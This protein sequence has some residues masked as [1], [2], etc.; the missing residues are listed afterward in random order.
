MRF[1]AFCPP[2]LVCL[3]LPQPGAADEP[4]F[5]VVSEIRGGVLAHDVAFLG[6]SEEEGV[7]INVELLFAAPWAAGRA[8]IVGGLLSPRP[9]LGLQA[10]TDGGASQAY[11]G[12]SW[13]IALAARLWFGLAAG[14][15]LHN[16]DLDDGPRTKALGSRVLFRLA[17][18]IGYDLTPALSVSLYYDHES[19]AGFAKDNEGLNNAGIRIGWLF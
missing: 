15:A 1:A 17:G 2:A 9:H 14:G 6:E 4:L 8:G 13:R 11:A 7:D 5:G 10:N 16:G 19:N 3:L 18:E 12:L